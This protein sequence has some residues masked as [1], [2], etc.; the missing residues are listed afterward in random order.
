MTLSRAGVA[1]GT[2]LCVASTGVALVLEGSS[3]VA[4]V[5]AGG[6]TSVARR[7][8]AG[9][10]SCRSTWASLAVIPSTVVSG[11]S[12]A[13]SA[14]ASAS[15]VVAAASAAASVV[16]ASAVTGAAG[17]SLRLLFFLKRRLKSEWRFFWPSG[18]GVSAAVAE[19]AS[20]SSVGPSILFS[21][22]AS[23]ALS[24]T[25]SCASVSTSWVAGLASGLVSVTGLGST[26]SVS[27]SVSVSALV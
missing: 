19:A 3:S 23:A 2:M 20:V 7:S 17:V 11:G 18:A 27:A 5:T 13:S 22:F 14:C 21:S 12:A 10:F 4:T 6:F 25:L 9:E 16:S 1:S 24:D 26:A 15:V 8:S